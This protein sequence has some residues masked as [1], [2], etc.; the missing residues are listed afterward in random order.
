[1]AE[2]S[3]WVYVELWPGEEKLHTLCSPEAKD[4]M[5]R[6]ARQWLRN[7]RRHGNYPGAKV[8]VEPAGGMSEREKSEAVGLCVAICLGGAE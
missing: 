5:V 3:F 7:K 6:F 4:R 8:V 1:M 2:E